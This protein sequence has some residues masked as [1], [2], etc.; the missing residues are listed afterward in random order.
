[1]VRIYIDSVDCEDYG[2]EIGGWAEWISWRLEE[3]GYPVIYPPWDFPPGSYSMARRYLAL[4][5][6]DRALFVVSGRI[7]TYS[8][9]IFRYA[10]EI[11]RKGGMSFTLILPD[12]TKYPAGYSFDSLRISRHAA[13]DETFTQ[14]LRTLEDR[15][16]RVGPENARKVFLAHASQDKDVVRELYRNLRNSGHIPWLDEED[17]LPGEDWDLVIH[18]EIESTDCVISCISSTSINKVGYIQKELKKILDVA[19]EYPEGRIFILPVR[20]DECT[21]PRK[22]QKIHCVDLFKEGGYG[23]ILK[24]LKAVPPREARPI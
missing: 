22:L 9:A 21:I 12:G 18:K 1:M 16:E 11:S 14:I 3:E 13:P 4:S 8:S 24:A 6:A 7:E 5:E 20:L 2:E 15:G 17:L 23:Q 19:D 10:E